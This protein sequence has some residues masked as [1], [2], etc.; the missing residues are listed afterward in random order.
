MIRQPR[1]EWTPDSSC[2]L[3]SW[4]SHLVCRKPVRQINQLVVANVQVLARHGPAV[5]V[6][7][8]YCSE[9]GLDFNTRPH[10]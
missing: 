4:D 5:F 8:E 2:A 3:L 9:V 1:R 10:Q 6:D 7:E